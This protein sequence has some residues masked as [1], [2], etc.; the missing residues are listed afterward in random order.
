MPAV[1]PPETVR[2][3]GPHYVLENALV[4]REIDHEDR[5]RERQRNM[6]AA[7]IWFRSK[8]KSQD[9]T[10]ITPPITTTETNPVP[11][12]GVPEIPIWLAEARGCDPLPD[13]PWQ[14]GAQEG[15]SWMASQAGPGLGFGHAYLFDGSWPSSQHHYYDAVASDPPPSFGQPFEPPGGPPIVYERA[16]GLPSAVVPPAVHGSNSDR[17]GLYPPHLG[18][19]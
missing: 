6:S 7:D 1:K 17:R 8:K 16:K 9:E 19:Y 5:E 11:I 12:V 2:L 18:N 14:D 4:Q 10:P 15:P 3:P 13:T